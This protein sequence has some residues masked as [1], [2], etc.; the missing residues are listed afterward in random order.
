MKISKTILFTLFL[1]LFFNLFISMNSFSDTIDDKV[2][3]ISNE[4]LCP[5]CRGQ[6]VAESNSDLAN[7]FR[8]IIKTKLNE[9]WT[10]DEILNYFTQRYGDTVLSSPPARGFRLV[11][12]ILPLAVI[13][14]GFI[15]LSRFLRSKSKTY[16][17]NNSSSENE[18]YLDEV[19]DQ[20]NK[21][22]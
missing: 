11:V 16:I 20:L 9:G 3:D 18:K 13:I 2:S 17:D 14:I 12:W 4:L 1:T 21:L 19:D 15:F 22:D 6:T 7:D 10:R 8:D 5:V